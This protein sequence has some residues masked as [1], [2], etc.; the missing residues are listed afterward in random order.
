MF[1]LFDFFTLFRLI[2]L[3]V[4][5]LAIINEKRVLGKCTLYLSRWIGQT[6]F[7]RKCRPT[8]WKTNLNSSKTN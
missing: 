4:N 2:V 8:I 7:K 3:V 6:R 5:A 1:F